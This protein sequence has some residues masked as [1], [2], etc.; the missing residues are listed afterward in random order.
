[1]RSISL[2]YA[3]STVGSKHVHNYF[4]WYLAVQFIATYLPSLKIHHLPIQ[5]LNNI[6]LYISLKYLILSI[7]S[8][9]FY[10]TVVIIAVLR[11][12]INYKQKI[13][14]IY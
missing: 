14:Y 6:T 12:E 4:W 5:Y 2:C 3:Q 10:S 7:W 9:S 13:E 11:V 1:M 8:L